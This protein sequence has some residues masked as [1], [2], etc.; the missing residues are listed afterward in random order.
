MTNV[1]LKPGRVKPVFAGHPWV[2][3]GAIERVE[4]TPAPGEAVDVRDPKGNLVGRG[5]YSPSSQIRVRMVTW[6]PDEALDDALL[7]R[8][9]AA[10]VSLRVRT[11][12]LD[13]AADAC[14][15][16]HGEGDGLPGLIVDLYPPFCVVQLNGAGVE[17]RRETILA[18]LRSALPGLTGILERS[19]AWARKEEGLEYREGPLWGEA[20]PALHKIR[21]NGVEHLADLARGQKTG[22]YLDQR[23]NRR[24]FASFLKGARL[25][26]A[27]AYTGAF[28]RE[29]VL[30]GGAREAV[31]VESGKKALEI[32]E[33]GRAADPAIPIRVEAGDFEKV[34]ALLKEGGERFDAVVLDPPPLARSGA[35]IQRALSHYA[36]IHRRAL[37]LLAPGG[38]LLSCCCSQRIGPEDFRRVLAHVAREQKREARV[39]DLWRESPDHPSRAPCE[40]SGYLKAF[41]LRVD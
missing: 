3:S 1:F 33:A 37:P 23:E 2:F 6:D 19:E 22:F 28:S 35:D 31:C 26:D 30:L 20:P 25:L 18:A 17:I 21:E 5:F 32:L 38:L 16:V 12:S 7:S 39:L 41:L 15:L 4:G 9:L 24:R 8:L 10:A 11:L 34:A 13:L 14:R 29:A 36:E 40:E 27:F